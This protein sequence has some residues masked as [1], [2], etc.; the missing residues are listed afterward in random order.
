MTEGP[1]MSKPRRPTK[2]CGEEFFDWSL[3]HRWTEES[4]RPCTET[5]GLSVVII[6]STCIY[7]YILNRVTFT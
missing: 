5:V 1:N 2:T 4:R 7:M 3:K 6:V